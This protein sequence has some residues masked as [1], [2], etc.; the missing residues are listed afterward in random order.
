MLVVLPDDL[1]GSDDGG[2]GGAER[3]LQKKS[4]QKHFLSCVSSVGS[5]NGATTRTYLVSVSYIV[6]HHYVCILSSF[7]SLNRKT[8]RGQGMIVLVVGLH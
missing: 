3:R 7:A 4:Q 1:S 5:K 8:P 2:D 6:S